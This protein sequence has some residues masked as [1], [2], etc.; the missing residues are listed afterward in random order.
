MEASSSLPCLQ[1]TSRVLLGCLHA[2]ASTQQ[3]H[4]KALLTCS[5]ELFSSQLTT[6]L[7]GVMPRQYILPHSLVQRM[8]MAL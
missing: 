1:P 3:Q 4:L 6:C 8:E 7:A 2:T 5:Q